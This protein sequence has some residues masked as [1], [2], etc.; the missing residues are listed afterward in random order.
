MIGERIKQARKA[1]GLSLRALAVQAGIS[2]MA[3][4]KYENGKSTPSSGVLLSLAQA[5]G[6]RTEYF[7]RQISVKLTDINHREH[8]KL[9]AKEEAKVIADV[10]EQLERWTDLENFVPS[11]WSVPFDLPGDLLGHITDYDEIE[12]IAIQ[13][14]H[15]WD[16]GLNSIPDLIDTL[17]AKGI[18]ILITRY[19][20]HK[21]F[22]GLSAQ[23]NDAPVVVVG[24]TWTGDRQ[25]FTLAHELGHLVLAGRLDSKLNEEAACHRFAGAFLVPE[26]MVRAAL[27]ARRKWLEPQEL[28]FL[29]HEWGLSMQAW[30]Y[31]ARDLGITTAKGHQE[32]WRRYLRKY[33]E[34]ERE[35]DPQFPQETTWLFPQLVYR[36]LAE[37]LV[38]EPKAAELLGMSVMDL[39]A[40]RKMECPE[41]I[42]DPD[43]NG[44]SIS[45]AVRVRAESSAE[46]TGYR[47]YAVRSRSQTYKS[48]TEHRVKRDAGTGRFIDTKK[49]GKPQVRKGKK[50]A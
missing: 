39:H 8:E 25:R 22:N 44:V 32:I 49:K 37:D 1:S 48:R 42:E 26:E 41:E 38:S 31:R 34:Q 17:E 2:A 33:K 10:E 45:S 9:P 18:K 29:K 50:R 19:D 13:V 27:G 43:D 4:S 28:M 20:G 5:L 24:Q 30:S 14:R 21:K 36:A 40:C 6:V 3:I 47:N 35:P 23:V 11:P 15:Y 7:F 16:L 12:K 46:K